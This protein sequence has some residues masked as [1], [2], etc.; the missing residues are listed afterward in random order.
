MV[1]DVLYHDGQLT[2]E[3]C[4]QE[5]DI[6]LSLEKNLRKNHAIA[7]YKYYNQIYLYVSPSFAK[8]FRKLVAK[9]LCH[10]QKLRNID[11]SA[12]PIVPS[13]LTIQ[14]F[15]LKDHASEDYQFR[16]NNGPQVNATRWDWYLEN[17]N[18]FV[19]LLR[20]QSYTDE[21]IQLCLRR[22]KLLGFE[23]VEKWKEYKKRHQRCDSRDRIN[24]SCQKYPSHLT[25]L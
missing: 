7:I 17:I 18:V 12:I 20:E 9:E 6:L 3:K 13:G 24:D 21:E 15:K 25:R 19:N 14:R 22:K 8:T 4:Q 23:S 16:I 1:Y 5:K 10:P 11:V 2:R